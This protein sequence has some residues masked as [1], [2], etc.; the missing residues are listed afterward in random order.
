MWTGKD[1]ENSAPLVDSINIGNYVR[2][3]NIVLDRAKTHSARVTS[4]DI[5]KDKLSYKWEIRPEARYASYAGQG[6]VVPEP[7][8]NLIQLQSDE[9]TFI[10]PSESGAYR[11]FVYVFDGKGHFSTSNLPFYV[12]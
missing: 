1:P 11:L 6:E 4:H 5:D 2:Y 3:Q 12:R 10:T 9:T 8:T 7:L